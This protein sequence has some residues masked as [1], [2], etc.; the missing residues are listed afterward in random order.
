MLRKETEKDFFQVE[1]EFKK[2]EFLNFVAKRVPTPIFGHFKFHSLEDPS[3][4]SAALA[5][6][7]PY[8]RVHTLFKLHSNTFCHASLYQ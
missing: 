8:L 4:H 5:A 2:F 3:A 6:G 1:K 7:T